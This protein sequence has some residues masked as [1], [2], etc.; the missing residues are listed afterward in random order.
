MSS[1]VTAALAAFFAVL[2]FVAGQFLQRFFLEPIQE[3]R[4]VIGEIAFSL[5]FHANAMDMSVRENQGLVLIEEPVE[6][7]KTL[8][9]LASR[10]RATLSTI[11]CYKLF[12]KL[13]IVLDEDSVMAASQSLVGWSNSIHHGD[14]SVHRKVV[15]EKLR[16]R[17]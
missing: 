6:I 17:E 7:V 11:P 2:V 4:Q 3:Q 5:L 9:G 1:L 14:P 13:G 16:L 8:R 12:A 10:L 15:A